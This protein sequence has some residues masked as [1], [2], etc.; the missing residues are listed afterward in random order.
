V[1]AE[2][3][4]LNAPLQI[5]RADL[6]I[7]ADSVEVT[8]VDASARDTN[9][10]GTLK[11]SRPCASPDSCNFEFHLRSPQ[12]SAASLNQLF[13]P[14]VAKHPW[15]RLLGIGASNSFFSK[16][17]ASG[18][19]AID[20]VTLGNTVCSH[21]STDLELDKAKLSL[22]KIRGNI[23]GGKTTGSIVADFSARPPAYSGTGSFDGISLATIAT[24]MH[25][26]WAEGS[27]AFEYQFKAAGWNISDLLNSADL[28][29]S[30]HI[31]DGVFPH[32]VL[33]EGAEPLHASTFSGQLAVQSGN[34]SFAKTELRNDDGV[35]TLTGAVTLAGALN[36]KMSSENSSSYALTGTLDQ[37]RVSPIPNPS[38]QAELKP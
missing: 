37:T 7:K 22:S 34:L 30:F 36:L 12:L 32:I 11:L 2:V 24:L 35:F 1:R 16:A 14:A 17:T 23:L 3:R 8:N 15:Y 10:H 9:W 6:L 5:H 33:V 13:N 29:A 20:K 27:A 25:T 28:S 21:F 18:T 19:I 38:T 31:K 4:G 26:E